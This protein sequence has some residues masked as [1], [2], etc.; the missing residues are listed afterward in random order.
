[1]PHSRTIIVIPARMQSTRLP[2]KMLLAKTGKPLIQHTYEAAVK[3]TKPERVV[4][5]TDHQDIVDA[6]TAFGGQ[7]VMTDPAL[8]SGTDRVAEVAR[9]FP[10][11]DIVANVQ[12]DEPEIEPESIDAAIESLEQDSTAVMST[13]ATPIRDENVLCDPGCVKVVFNKAGDAMYFSRSPI[14]FARDGF[15]EKLKI[16]PPLFHLHVGLYCYRRDF[17]GQINSLPVSSYEE[18]EKLEQLRVLENG[19]RIKTAVIPESIPGIDTADDYEAFVKRSL[20]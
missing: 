5:A 3:A 20:N 18:T 8:P 17:L 1:M 6:V 11:F 4:I 15:A 12:G 14:P 10:E 9:Q 13:L 7:A 16:S 19:F 2:Q